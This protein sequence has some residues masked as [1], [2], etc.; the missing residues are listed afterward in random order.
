MTADP[1]HTL[2]QY[3]IGA[4]AAIDVRSPAEYAQ[5]H[6]PGAINLPILDDEE[7]RQVGTTY[8]N[9]GSDAAHA[10]GH[11]LVSGEIRQARIAAWLDALR[12]HPDAYLYCWRG[13]ARSTIAAQWLAE[14]GQQPWRVP[15]GYK[16]IRA[17][18]LETLAVS[19][20]QTASWW[21][22]GGRTGSGKTL[23]LQTLRRAVDLEG[24][25]A[26]R[27]SAFGARTTPQPAV[28]TFEN[29]LA[30]ALLRLGNSH[31]VLEDESR[32]IGRLAIPEAVHRA[33]QRAP[34]ALLETPLEARIAN[35]RGEY[36]TQPLLTTNPEALE[37]HYVRA[38]QRI[39]RRLGGQRHQDVEQA[40]RHGFATGEHDGWIE[41]LLTWYYDPM[42]D[43]QLAQKR[44]RIRYAGAAR[45][46]GAFLDTQLEAGYREIAG[47]NHDPQPG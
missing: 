8:R 18:C 15:G 6:L 1:L 17:L 38:L 29:T 45:D 4:T 23:L 2:R 5:G 25:A 42:Y 43:Y 41:R 9:T 46:V 22:L 33:M 31:L 10:L 40:L 21:L 20:P 44:A 37:A 35:I 26:H 3:L 7:R 19:V 13:G 14:Q 47:D 11:R 30:C 28:A 32:M 27:G 36:V 39:R 16:A 34:V 24:L 12:Q